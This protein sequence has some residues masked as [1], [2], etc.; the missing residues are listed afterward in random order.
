[1]IDELL[2]LPAHPLLVHAAVV[3]TPL[4][5]GLVIG[6]AVVPP[7][8]K[9]IA[10]A[11]VAV[12]VIA[13]ISLFLAKESGEQFVQ[14]RAKVAGPQFTELMRP[15]SEYAERAF[16]YGA[17][18]GVLALVLVYV[19]TSAAKR[20]ANTRSQVL[21]YGVAVLSIV[22]A[23]VTGYYIFKTGDSGARQVWG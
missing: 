11:V 22:A 17:A 9:W 6:Y 1:M 15:H 20:P 14:D 7:I 19:V 4:L 21:T 23:A 10:W 8:R 3:F 18:L 16:W 5:V 13:P 2:G 12:G